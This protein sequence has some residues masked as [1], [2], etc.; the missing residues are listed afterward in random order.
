MK[1]YSGELSESEVQTIVKM[2]TSGRF[3]SKHSMK[4]IT[5]C[6]LLCS[7]LGGLMGLCYLLFD[8]VVKHVILNK[9]ILT[10]NSEIADFWQAPPITPH[11]KIYFF[12][13]TNAAQVFEGSEIPKLVEVGPYTYHQKWTKEKVHWHGNGTMSYSTRKH[14]TF[15]PSLS[16]GD[17]SKDNIT[18]LNIPMLTSYYQM[19]D[20][21]FMT[22]W[23]L[24]TILYSLN[25]K[26]WTT[27]TVEE[28][29]WGYDEPLFDLARLTLPN[30]PIYNKFGLFHDKNTTDGP[31]PLYTMYTG[32][33]N[34]YNLS[35]IS[36]FNGKAHLDFWKN[37]EC[38]LVQG[39]DGATF[40]PYI[41]KTDTLYFFNDQLCRSIPLR[42]SGK[43]VFSKQ[44]PGFRFVPR[45]DV[46]KSP[47][48]VPANQ[49]FCTDQTLC[50]MLGDGMFGVSK[51][52]FD[53]PIVLSWP[54]FLHANQSYIDA[55]DGLRPNEDKHGFYFDIQPITGTTLA[56]K[57]RI[58]I[59]FAIKQ[60]EA[61]GDMGQVKN[62]I[63]PILW[64]EEGLDE[65]G[66]PLVD[67]ISRAVLQPPLYKN[68]I[69]CVLVGL[70]IST[71]FIA[72]VAITRICLNI[73]NKRMNETNLSTVRE[74]ARNLLQNQGHHC[75]N[76]RPCFDDSSATQPMLPPS[77]T[78][79]LSSASTS[80]VTTATSSASHSRNTSAG[81]AS[82]FVGP[83]EQAEKLRLILDPTLDTKN[84]I[85]KFKV[86][87]KYP[88]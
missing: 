65:L 79:C 50:N 78:S 32:E 87:K 56:A 26:P 5:V 60:S 82:T 37:D 34:P 63:L 80:T 27:K 41:Q 84:K 52:Q 73:K 53:A 29:I 39:S 45:F 75:H 23:G 20:A 35:K 9:L 74:T 7:V 22:A 48:S 21:N 81:S 28:L 68:Y 88:K 72:L 19:R 49:C 44:L 77:S 36:L 31:L 46:F 16:V 30:P 18:T 66:A 64:F 58:Q 33:G 57:A 4:S 69:L 40:N 43:Q 3:S 42:F 54:H 6:L 62:T 12:N 59:N 2:S 71:L 76:S 67:A 13:L 83:C 51:C 10:N 25:Y 38:N 15:M 1:N 55:V 85:G 14:Y 70:T 11:L 8:P 24:E 47:S 86:P 17:H 61:F